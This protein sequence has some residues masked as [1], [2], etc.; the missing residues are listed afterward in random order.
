MANLDHAEGSDPCA[1]AADQTRFRRI[2]FES[3]RGYPITCSITKDGFPEALRLPAL[4]KASPS[5]FGSP[6]AKTAGATFR[7]ILVGALRPR[8]QRVSIRRALPGQLNL[9]EA[10]GRYC[11]CRLESRPAYP[12]FPALLRVKKSPS[13]PSHRTPPQPCSRN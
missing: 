8:T 1:L 4:S 5:R 13:S 10:D 2:A 3:R 12:R 11:N 6:C 9:S 7:L